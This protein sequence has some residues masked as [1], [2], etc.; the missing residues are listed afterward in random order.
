MRYGIPFKN[1]DTLK[2]KENMAT[3]KVLSGNDAIA[4]AVRQVRPDVVT[5]YPVTPASPITEALAHHI[6]NGRMDAELVNTESD[7]SSMSACIGA[8][9]GGGRVFTATAS[10]GLAFMHEILFVAASLRLPIVAAVT[11]RALS[12]PINVHPDHSDAMAQR[13]TG[14]IQLFSENAQEAYDNIIQAFKIA[15]HPEVKTPV[16]VGLD[17]FI[18]SH[19]LTNLLVE[20]NPEVA[21]FVGKCQPDYS[22]L[23]HQSPV[24]AGSMD[25]PEYYF[26]HKVNQ[27]Q[28]IETA[29][30]IIKDVGK[31]FGHRFGRYYGNFESYKLDD[32]D[33]AVVMMSSGA[34][35]AKEVVDQLRAKG[36]KV[37][38]L[39]LRVFRPFP[40]RALKERLSHLKAVAVLDR[41]FAPGSFGGPLFNEIRCALYDAEERPAVHPYIYGLG[42]RDITRQHLRDLFASLADTGRETEPVEIETGYIN[43]RA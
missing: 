8:S 35:T 9:A 11:N 39:K 24:S 26:E 16:M 2:V 43:L 17:G 42:G 19:T 32:A 30:K 13:D 10:Q 14:W 36:E 38:L 40:H 5:G 41:S 4:E 27:L 31:E 25:T 37:G 34:G 28:G 23:D 18:T 33:V 1:N 29:R 7:H 12:A 3:T 21:D 20:D 22:L 6:A 15:E